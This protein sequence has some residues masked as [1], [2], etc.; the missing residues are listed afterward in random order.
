ME[1]QALIRYWKTQIVDR[2]YLADAGSGPS[3]QQPPVEEYF[4]LETTRL[5]LVQPLK[6]T[7]T[8]APIRQSHGPGRRPVGQRR[9]S[10]TG[11][12]GSDLCQSDFRTTLK[13]PV[14]EARPRVKERKKYG[15][16]PPRA[17]PV[18]QTLNRI[19][20]Q[21]QEE[22]GFARSSF[23]AISEAS[24]QRRVG[25]VPGS[26]RSQFGC[27]RKFR[28]LQT[29]LDEDVI[30]LISSANIAVVITPAIRP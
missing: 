27:R 24:H 21:N 8:T 18:L 23:Y 12:H 25:H 1:M 9:R 16:A 10:V 14:R 17:V 19:I 4:P 11:S 22:R 5:E 20:L 7:N 26:H 13:K 15:Q 29:R 28:Q 2:P 3:Y 6:L 30:P